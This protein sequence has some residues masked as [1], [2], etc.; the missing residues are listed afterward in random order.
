V[1]VD[2]VLKQASRVTPI[3]VSQFSAT[4][5]K[6]SWQS[7]FDLLLFTENNLSAHSPKG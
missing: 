1:A 5:L 3:D 2:T 4:A 7:A 6:V